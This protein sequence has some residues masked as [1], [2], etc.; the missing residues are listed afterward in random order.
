MTAFEETSLWADVKKIIQDGDKVAK[1]DYTGKLHTKSADINVMKILTIDIVRDYVN[2]IGDQIGVS[3][4]MPLGQYVKKL[5]PYRDNLE[6]TLI[7]KRVLYSDSELLNEEEEP[8]EERF[9]AV[10]V[11]EN[12]PNVNGSEYNTIDEFTLDHVEIVTVNLQLVDRQLEPMRAKTT[13][14]IF[15]NSSIGDIIKSVMMG[16][17]NKISVE[18]KKIVQSFD[19]VEPNNTEQRKT[20][21]IPHSTLVSSLPTYL[22]EAMGGVYNAGVGTYLQSFSD[23]VT[24]FVYP[25][26]NTTRINEDAKKAIF[27]SVPRNR[28]PAIER[29]YRLDSDILH[30][31]ASGAKAIQNTGEAEYMNSGSGY[32]TLDAK[33]VMT[34][35][36]E[37]TEEGPIAT[38]ATINHEVAVKE[39]DDGLNY[40]PA[41]RK[42]VSSNSYV[43][44]S[45]INLKSGSRIDLTW[46][47]ANADLICPNM[48]CKFIYLDDNNEVKELSGV[49]VAVQI[50]T[51]LD[52]KSVTTEIY[53][54]SAAITMYCETLKQST[55]D[56]SAS[57]SD[58]S[59]ISRIS[60]FLESMP[61]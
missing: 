17:S 31:I 10:F 44:A 9:K 48:P 47:N 60:N 56:D 42:A 41:S 32:R 54:T 33:S 2:N 26:F 50:F 29:S 6:F 45:Q 38:R 20:T 27:Y 3:F 23:K 25:L 24:W 53:T 43:Q 19:I 51:K 16:E 55:S 57:T 39:R 52:G 14:G 12:N 13:G 8:Y 37:T 18:G 58:S 30:V 21:V 7:K 5:Y 59:T 34:K 15:E 4:M 61:F 46:D 11:V 36:V 22:Q 1:H 35:P 40:A 49:I 28:Y